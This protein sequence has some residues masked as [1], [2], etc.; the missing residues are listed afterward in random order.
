MRVSSRVSICTTGKRERMT[1]ARSRSVSAMALTE[2]MQQFFVDAAEAAVAHNQYMVSRPRFAGD[3]RDEFSDVVMDFGL[4]AE[5][6]KR[7]RRIPA[8]VRA[9]A[10][11]A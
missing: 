11:H 10:I 6:G 5:R 4:R 8:E 9:V 7:R 3:R 2:L 1:T